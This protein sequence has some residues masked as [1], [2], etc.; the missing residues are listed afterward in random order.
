MSLYPTGRLF[1]RLPKTQARDADDLS[2]S[3][4]R[5]IF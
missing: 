1:Y 3:P 5:Q 4:K 2:Q